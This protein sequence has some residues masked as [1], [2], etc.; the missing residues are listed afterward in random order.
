LLRIHLRTTPETMRPSIT[1]LSTVIFASSLLVP[2]SYAQEE[3]DGVPD[4]VVVE[5]A[6]VVIEEER[7]VVTPAG[8]Q[9]IVD[10]LSRAEDFT[11]VVAAIEAAGLT[12]TLKGG[13]P[14]TMFVPMNAAFNALPAGALP[15]LMKEGNEL[16][17]ST[18]LRYHV[19]PGRHMVMDLAAGVLP[20]VHGNNL[21]VTTQ[22]VVV[23][24]VGATPVAPND[25]NLPVQQQN[26]LIQG[27]SL[28]RTD[29]VASNGIIHVVDRVLL[30]VA[31]VRD[32]D[33]EVVERLLEQEVEIRTE[34]QEVIA[35]EAE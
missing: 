16:A 26:V 20:T 12:E 21:E 29:I 9:D 22:S 15:E 4:G 8:T 27:A 7:S 25:P 30:P 3:N 35:E 28:L 6:P 34:V 5:P 10:I 31:V 11:T 1:R 18:I 23:D 13:G 17:L 19:V 32:P 14:F 33:A 2:L 24:R